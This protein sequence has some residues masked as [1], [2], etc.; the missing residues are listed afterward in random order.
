MSELPT[1]KVLDAI[2]PSNSGTGESVLTYGALKDAVEK[3]RLS[4]PSRV[5]A[6]WSSEAGSLDELSSAEQLAYEYFLRTAD[7]LVDSDPG[8]RDLWADRFTQASIELYGSPD[9]TQAKQLIKDEY[10]QLLSLRG[11]EGI[12]QSHLSFLLE[13]YE[14]FVIDEKNDFTYVSEINHEK[15]AIH[16]YGQAMLS[17]YK[18]IFDTIDQSGK[19]EF[20]YRDLKEIF[21]STLDWLIENDDD[22]WSTWS[23]VETD[24]SALSVDATSRLIKIASRREPASLRDT[25]GLIAHELLVHALRGKNAYKSGK[26]ELATGLAGYLNAEEGLGILAEEAV[27]GELPEKAYDR[28]VD[29]AL[30]LG[31]VDGVQRSRKDVYMISFSRQLLRGQA[32]GTLTETDVSSLEIR[33]WGH[34]D[35]IYRGGLGDDMGLRQAI[36]TKDIAYYVGYKHMAEYI[37]DQIASGKTA[38]EIFSYLSQ[39]KFDPTNLQHVEILKG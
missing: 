26:K 2:K 13:T 1:V 4:N 17:E 32:K 6:F 25:R 22:S 7:K 21:Q 39:G 30:A 27:N 19:T 38:S 37:S 12:S 9:Q 16:E 24:G 31:T 10:E 35:R 14:P 36:F 33:V 11:V 8:N 15:Q 28:Y 18:P 29:I 5:N 20:S 3:Y 34:V 23:V